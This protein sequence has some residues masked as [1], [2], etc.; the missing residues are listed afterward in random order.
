MTPIPF[1]SI[2]P[3]PAASGRSTSRPQPGPAIGRADPRWLLAVRVQL[4]MTG[5]P[6]LLPAYR[7]RL[8]ESATRLGFMPIHAASII[9][10]AERS[11]QAGGLD[12]AASSEIAEIPGPTTRPER[13][14][15]ALRVVITGLILVAFA[16][17]LLRWA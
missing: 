6:C 1:Q 4:L 14:G 3:L 7:E 17:V 10:I 13:L 11:V 12:H 16:I 8:L 5:Q 15:V 2:D 9:A